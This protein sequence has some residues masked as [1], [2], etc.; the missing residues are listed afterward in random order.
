MKI[1]KGHT[2]E[3]CGIDS[4]PTGRYVATF[5]HH[6][7]YANI[8]DIEAESTKTLVTPAFR[9]NTGIELSKIQ[10]R[11]MKKA[12]AILSAL[13]KQQI[14]LYRVKF[15]QTEQKTLKVNGIIKDE[16]AA[17]LAAEFFGKSQ[18]MIA[19]DTPSGCTFKELSFTSEDGS[20]IIKEQTVNSKTG[21]STAATTAESV[22]C[23]YSL[24]FIV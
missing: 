23:S 9:V 12:T 1:I 20:K 18:L 11:N 21:K 22:F 13:N 24:T 16:G 10:F 4:D 7:S 3:I 8:W 5:A 6:D 2:D 15:A 19:F 14:M 17:I